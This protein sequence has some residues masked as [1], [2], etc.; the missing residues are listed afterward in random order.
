MLYGASLAT[1]GG[2]KGR[3]RGRKKLGAPPLD[4]FFSKKPPFSKY[5]AYISLYAFAIN[6]DGTDKLSSVPP[7]F[8]KFLDPPLFKTSGRFKRGKKGE[9]APRFVSSF[10]R[11]NSFS[12][13]HLFLPNETRVVHY[14][15]L[16]Q[17][18]TALIHCLPSSPLKIYGFVTGYN[19]IRWRIPDSK[20][21]G[22][23]GRPPYWLIFFSKSAFFRVKGIYFVVRICDK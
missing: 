22:G 15:H 6:E 13:S 16:R 12:V 20:R 10:W 7:P 1:S 2:F 14:V 23:G 5:K 9:T 18:T 8:S 11:Q 4:I 21:S 17:G 19:S 3:G